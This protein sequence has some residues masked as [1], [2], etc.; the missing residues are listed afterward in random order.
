MRSGDVHQENASGKLQTICDRVIKKYERF[1]ILVNYVKNVSA[2]L[3]SIDAVEFSESGVRGGSTTVAMLSMFLF[4]IVSIISLGFTWRKMREDVD[5][6]D[7]IASLK[8][9]KEFLKEVPLFEEWI[10]DV[11][12]LGGV[13]SDTNGWGAMPLV[14]GGCFIEIIQK[15]YGAVILAVLIVLIVMLIVFFIRLGLGV[16]GG[17]FFEPERNKTR[18]RPTPN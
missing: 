4:L 1:P 15:K 3:E 14:T 2:I 7:T 9:I 11:S 10:D 12:N 18:C 6:G 16:Y 8:N 13:E 17:R 5:T